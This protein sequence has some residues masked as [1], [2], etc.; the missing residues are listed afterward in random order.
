LPLHPARYAELLH[1]RLNTHGSQVWLVN[2]GWT[3]GPYGR[4]RRVPLAFTRA[5]VRAILNGALND[6]VFEPDPVFGV[7]VPRAC[8]GVPAELLRPAA[9]W[10]DP[11]AYALAARELAELFQANFASYAPQTSEG[12]RQAGPRLV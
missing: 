1:E 9:T 10:S 11:E 8:P 5:M 7:L 6:A 12:V 3:G 2:T 4:G